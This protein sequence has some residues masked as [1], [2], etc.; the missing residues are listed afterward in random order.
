MDNRHDSAGG[1]NG[2]GIR[3]VGDFFA[4]LGRRLSLRRR[5][6][7]FDY[8]ATHQEVFRRVSRRASRE[9]AMSR[10]VGGSFSAM[11]AILRESLIAHAH[12]AP[13]HYVIDVGC[14][15]GRLAKALVPYLRG[16]L[17][18]T[19]VVP[20][21]LDYAAEVCGRPDWRFIR[22]NEIAIPERDNQADVVVF[23]SVMT[24]LLHE[25]SYRYLCEARR[26]LKPGGRVVFSFLDFEA[27][28][29]WQFFELM[30]KKR[31]SGVLKQHDQFIGRDAIASWSR[32]AG[33][34][35]VRIIRADEP[36]ADLREPV[37]TDDGAILQGPVSM[38]QS[39]CVLRK[40]TP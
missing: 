40:P 22:V 24:H 31:A 28:D 11:G 25:D 37:T 26:V 19:D 23:Y 2:S 17:L 33:L 15:S 12:L 27:P 6:A 9:D 7:A 30:V 18:G 36:V 1:R 38:H 34:E 13:D 8:S 39:L 14:G 21:V 10:A 32:N 35:V 16:P 20:A 3:A 29:S 4:F 5:V